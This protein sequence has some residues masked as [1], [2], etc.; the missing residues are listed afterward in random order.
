MNSN[1]S[2]RFH[3]VGRSKGRESRTGNVLDFKHGENDLLTGSLIN[4]IFLSQSGPRN[5]GGGGRSVTHINR[6]LK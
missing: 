3:E 4:G 2:K 6:S 1:L 5:Q